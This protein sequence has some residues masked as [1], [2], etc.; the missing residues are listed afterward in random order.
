[1]NPSNQLNEQTIKSNQTNKTY[2][3]IAG[4]VAL[5]ILGAIG[6]YAYNR[7]NSS[8]ENVKQPVTQLQ[9]EN[10][11]V[12]PVATTTEDVTSP[13]GTK[14]LSYG[15]AIKAYPFRFQF[16][17][18][19]GNPGTMA[20]KTGA[21]VMLDNRDKVAHTIKA[22]GQTFKIGALDYALLKTS[23]LSNTF[24]TCDG[25]GSAMLNVQK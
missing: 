17:N 23:A 11:V 25:G 4:V 5:L 12:S 22:D 24:V 2:S 21:I 1:M 9:N 6:V 15:E 20:V 7:Q 19:S 18:C 14:K 8:D 13:V 10:N 16:V 3:Y